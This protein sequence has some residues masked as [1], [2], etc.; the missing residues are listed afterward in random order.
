MNDRNS[1]LETSLLSK[2]ERTHSCRCLCWQSYVFFPDTNCRQS[3]YALFTYFSTQRDYLLTYN[4]IRTSDSN[5][6]WTVSS[7]SNGRSDNL[8]PSITTFETPIFSTI[9]PPADKT[10]DFRITF[11]L[12]TPGL[13][14]PHEKPSKRRGR[15][16]R[17]T[18]NDIRKN[19]T[20][21]WLSTTRESLQLSF[22]P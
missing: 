6:N 11:A 13:P 18:K 19:S 1:R 22:H 21:N 12:R 20:K 9:R 2:N 8:R 17:P 15:Q 5:I 14:S 4:G 10:T 16:H 3:N 7:S